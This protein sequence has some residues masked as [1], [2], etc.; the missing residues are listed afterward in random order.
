M[1]IC[2]G[3]LI[4]SKELAINFGYVIVGPGIWKSAG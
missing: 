4:S 3:G 1:Y 2:K